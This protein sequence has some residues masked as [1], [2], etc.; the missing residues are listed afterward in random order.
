MVPAPMGRGPGRLVGRHG[1]EV[2]LVEH[3]VGHAFE[4]FVD[5]IRAW[6]A[7]AR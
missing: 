1:I 6:I 5:D 2:A 3:P 7:T 4:P